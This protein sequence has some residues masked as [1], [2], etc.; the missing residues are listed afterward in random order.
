MVKVGFIICPQYGDMTWQT[1][2]FAAVKK[3]AGV[4]RDLGPAVVVG[5]IACAG[6][7]GKRVVDRA[8]L[9][10]KCG[11]DIIAVSSCMSSTAS[12]KNACPYYEHILAELSKQLRST[13]VIDCRNGVGA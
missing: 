9:L 7:P 5:S 4:F 1:K 8:K 13:I 3:G 6:C 2:D 11:A 12:D 10:I